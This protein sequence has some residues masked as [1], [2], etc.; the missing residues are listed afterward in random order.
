MDIAPFRGLRFALSRLSE[1]H[2]G[3]RRSSGDVSR[4]VTSPPYDV[5][6]P[7]EHR[8]LLE[9]SPYNVTRLTLGTVPGEASSYE[10][11]GK[12]VDHWIES[13]V[14][15]AD[16]TPC[17]YAYEVDYPVP[18]AISGERAHMIGLVALGRLSP[19]EDGV[20]LP[21]ER[22]FP[23]VVDDRKKLLE[24]TRTNLESILLLYNDSAGEIDSLLEEAASAGGS[25]SSSPS[26]GRFSAR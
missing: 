20:V 25:L 23:K 6:S 1:F 11:R 3:E 18:G 9:R 22:T 13:G 7:E 2:G 4:A 17:F 8:E 5:I 19:F 12:L 16:D 14:L 26:R 10:E 24:A 15:E 21:H